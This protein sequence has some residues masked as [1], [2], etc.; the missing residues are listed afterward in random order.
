MTQ[1]EKWPEK[2]RLWPSRLSTEAKPLSTISIV[3]SH[4]TTNHGVRTLTCSKTYSWTNWPKMLLLYPYN[5]FSSIPSFCSRFLVV[6]LSYDRRSTLLR[7]DRRKKVKD[8]FFLIYQIRTIE[9]A[10]ASGLCLLL[11]FSVSDL[12][13]ASSI[14][15]SPRSSDYPSK[16]FSGLAVGLLS[17]NIIAGIL[18]WQDCRKTWMGS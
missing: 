14:P 4:L 2:Q 1:E 18:Y 16:L 15:S 3:R 13:R 8:V 9:N 11:G 10:V 5:L 6:L 17:Y 12:S 7:L